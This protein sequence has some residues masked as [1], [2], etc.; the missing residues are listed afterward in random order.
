LEREVVN[1][2]SIDTEED[3]P[4][5]KKMNGLFYRMGSATYWKNKLWFVQNIL[6]RRFN[7]N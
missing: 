3:V 7:I 5:R 1:Q 4:I 2:T 6:L